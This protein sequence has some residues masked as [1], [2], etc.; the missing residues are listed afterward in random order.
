MEFQIFWT[1]EL[2]VVSRTLESTGVNEKLAIHSSKFACPHHGRCIGCR[3]RPPG[4]DPVHLN[5]DCRAPVDIAACL[6][7]VYKFRIFTANQLAPLLYSRGMFSLLRWTCGTRYSAWALCNYAALLSAN[8]QHDAAID[9]YSRVIALDA[10]S[11]EYW[12]HRGAANYNAGNLEDADR[13]L[14]QAI[15]LDRKHEIALMYR[16]CTRLSL[17]KL[18]E[19][20][21]DL[22]RIS[23]DDSEYST[24]ALYR[25]YCR[26]QLGEWQ[27]AINE[28]LLAHDLSPSETTAAISLARIQAGCPVDDVRNGS[29]AV[30]NAYRMC[31][32]TGWNNWIAIS[33]LAAAHAEAG[34]FHTAVE[35]ANK[36]FELAADDEKTERRRRVEQFK[37][38][39]PF[40]ISETDHP[41]PLPLETNTT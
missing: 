25:G 33:V 3:L 13:D 10:S 21:A 12:A 28:Y 5:P 27:D 2:V 17:G 24:I 29:K 1:A 23:C 4:L 39:R 15:I 37:A 40:R 35:F 19:A 14:T 26:E 11:A 18:R 30:E 31:V 34:N 38:G 7:L 16:G 20:L 8:A 41:P 36:A 22:E 6:H 9:A 32:R